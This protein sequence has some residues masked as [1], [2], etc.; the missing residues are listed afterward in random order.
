MCA[1]R[2]ATGYT[3]AGGE[4]LA[5]VASAELHRRGVLPPASDLVTEDLGQRISDRFHDDA[6]LYE[7]ATD[8]VGATALERLRG[9]LAKD[10][11]VTT[12]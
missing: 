1:R 12:R 10:P 8:Q 9:V 3:E 6:M 5:D 7:A 2:N 4:L 11:P